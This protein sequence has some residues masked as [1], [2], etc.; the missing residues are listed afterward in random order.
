MMAEGVAGYLSS[1]KGLTRALVT[2]V[3]FCG[4]VSMSSADVSRLGI[5]TSA[6]QARFY[7]FTAWTGFLCSIPLLLL[8]TL[9]VPSRPD[10]RHHPWHA[11]ETIFS[12]VWAFFFFIASCVVLGKSKDFWV[13][14]VGD[15]GAFVSAGFFGLLATGLY[16]LQTYF[17]WH[18]WRGRGR[19]QVD[20]GQG[21][22]PTLYDTGVSYQSSEPASPGFRP[23]TDPSLPPPHL[24]A[25][26]QMMPLKSPGRGARLEFV[27]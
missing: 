13:V 11:V 9:G 1:G 7:N 22:P 16:S 3:T 17:S 12:S 8:H 26:E 4:A 2:L 10:L 6:S 24:V 25:S 5:V 15:H 18:M 21:E 27:D 19:D 20:W 14:N 23:G